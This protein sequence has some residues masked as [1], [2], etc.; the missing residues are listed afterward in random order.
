M[1]AGAIRLLLLLS[2]LM[3]MLPADSQSLSPA[4]LDEVLAADATLHDLSF[5][6]AEKG[7]VVGDR[8][9]VLATD[10]GG[11]HWHK[12]SVPVDCPLLAVH[13]VDANRGWIVGGD[14]AQL[15]HRSRGVVLRT[16]NGGATWQHVATP[17]LPRLTNIK[18]FDAANGI[19][20]G[21]GAAFYPSGLF[22]SSDG[23][24]S[25]QPLAAGER[26]TWL[27]ADFI[28]PENGALAGTANAR[29]ALIA[30]E[31]KLARLAMTSSQTP[32]DMALGVNGSGWMVGTRGMITRTNDGG[33]SWQPL[34][35]PPLPPTVSRQV[36][37]NTVATHSDN[38]WIAGSPGTLVIHSADGGRTWSSQA[39]GL[40]APIRR[41][42]FVDAQSGWAIGDLGTIL[43]TDDGGRTWQV[44]R[45]GGGRAAMLAVCAVP[46]YAPLEIISRYAVGEGYRT[47]AL[48]LFKGPPEPTELDDFHRKAAALTECGASLASALWP[49]ST[50]AVGHHRSAADLVA[51]LDRLSDGKARDELHHQLVAAIRTWRPDVLLVPHQRDPSGNAA[52]AVAEQLALAAVDAAADPTHAVELTTVAALPP[53]QVKRIV[54]LT[55]PGERGSI[56]LPTD[57]FVATL[58]G[59]PARWSSPARGLLFTQHTVPP[60]TD[61]LE[62]L[63]QADGLTNSSRDL[64]A[65]LN[66]PPG[67]DA[68]RPTAPTDPSNLDRLRRLTLKRRQLVRL[69]DHAKGGPAWSA[70]VVNLTGGLDPQTGGELLVQLAEGYRETG[71]LSMAADTLY[72]LARR[73]PD[74]PLT[75]QALVWLVQYYASGELALFASREEARDMRTRPLANVEYRQPAGATSPP[76]VKLSDDGGGN[77]SPDERLERAAMLGK[78]LEQSRPALYAEPALRFPLA[79]ASRR[80]GFSATADRYY[81]IASKSSVEGAWQRAARAER[82]LAKPTELPPEKPLVSCRLVDEAPHLDGL[83]DE[84]IWDRAEP[85]KLTGGESAATEEHATIV[86]LCRDKDYL[87]LAITC[88]RLPQQAYADDDRPRPRD[89]DLAQFDRV[90]LSLDID[91][92]YHTAYEL[93]VDCRGWTHDAAWNDAK[94]NPQW[95]IAHQLDD[96][97]WTTELAIPWQELSDPQP[98]VR[99]TWALRAERRTPRGH[100]E[101]WTGATGA[102]PDSFGLLLFR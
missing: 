76:P 65:G 50:P 25:W 19:A 6:N 81:L 39:T 17:T 18:F 8:G 38:V 10:N 75:E 59:S 82:W 101:S 87:Y 94:W 102:T 33:A 96:T 30:R 36:D 80:L 21:Y 9:V 98:A 45:A 37:W 78:Y 60:S 14:A 88:P 44:Q 41:L 100:Q 20:T 15:T 72:L 93:T 12:Q 67:S 11:K 51:E 92:D 49:G 48:P 91:R 62:L 86:R 24:K 16:I 2:A 68:R 69:L 79:I 77:L 58:G 56:R 43:A 84:E 55:P 35:A 27:A 70:Q 95:Y 73:Y 13:F 53:W 3:H 40:V 97:N 23:G 29:G 74:H 64:F 47:V 46:K 28:D 34:V 90:H 7:W 66:I 89:A 61:E 83:F 26:L 5:V 57:D 71:R 32:R 22:T 54:G 52:S 42:Q 4:T 99:D 63:W 31:L 85:M 1:N